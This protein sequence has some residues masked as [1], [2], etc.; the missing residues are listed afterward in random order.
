LGHDAA[1]ITQRSE[2]SEKGNEQFRFDACGTSGRTEKAERKKARQKKAARKAERLN[3]HVNN[4]IGK[5]QKKE[6][7]GSQKKGK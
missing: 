4:C 2:Q 1:E 7:G 6:K 5:A 3:H